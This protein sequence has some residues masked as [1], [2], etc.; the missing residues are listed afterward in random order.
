MRLLQ[1]GEV[2]GMIGGFREPLASVLDSTVWPEKAGVWEDDSVGY[3]SLACQTLRAS[4]SIGR[5]GIRA[6]RGLRR[7]PVCRVGWQIWAMKYEIPTKYHIGFV[8]HGHNIFPGCLRS[9]NQA[10]LPKKRLLLAR[11]RNSLQ[12]QLVVSSEVTLQCSLS[13]ILMLR[14]KKTITAAH[15]RMNMITAGLLGPRKTFPF[16]LPYGRPFFHGS[17][18]QPL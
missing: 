5:A 18:T 13:D 4:M 10:H 12:Y 7:K 17:E 14:T 2:A 11:N 3:H 16:I 6:C 8:V 15:V 1:G 9:F